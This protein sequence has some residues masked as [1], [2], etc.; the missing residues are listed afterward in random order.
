MNKKDLK[1]LVKNYFTDNKR[2]F[3]IFIFVFVLMALMSLLFFGG[4]G[5]VGIITL[6]ISFVVMII[7]IYWKMWYVSNVAYSD[8]RKQR[9]V[10]KN[11]TF[12]L[13]KE[14]KSWI[15]WNSNPKNSSVCKYIAMDADGNQ[16]RLCTTCNYQNVQAVE[17]FLSSNNFRIVQLEKS[18]LIIC[19]QNNPANFKNKK[20]VKEVT[21]TTKAL[22]GPFSFAFSYKND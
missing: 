4:N 13:L 5:G 2:M 14:D 15:L 21:D 3:G 1:K 20:E 9:F 7:A 8:I 6:V 22:F 12:S 11:V 10:K 18:K 17:K 16:Y 19:I